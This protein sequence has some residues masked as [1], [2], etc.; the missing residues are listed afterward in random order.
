MT[1]GHQELFTWPLC[2]KIAKPQLS[3]VSESS[4][5]TVHITKV[6]VSIAENLNS[7]LS[8]AHKYH[9]GIRWQNRDLRILRMR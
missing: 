3:S 9:Y 2:D 5:K 1:Y 8:L 4:S 6:E 7:E